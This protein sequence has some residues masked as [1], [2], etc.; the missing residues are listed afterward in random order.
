MS[1]IKPLSKTFLQKGRF[2]LASFL[3]ISILFSINPQ[4]ARA[5]ILGDIWKAISGGNSSNTTDL[6]SSAAAIA[7]PLLGSN[8]NQASALTGV[9]GSMD[10]S[11]PDMSSSQDS[12]LVAPRN[13]AGTLPSSGSDQ[14]SIYTVASGDTPGGIADKFGISL[15]TLLW[16][17]NLKNSR[18]IKAGDNLV[19][20]PVSGVQYEVKKGDTVESIA[21]KYRPKDMTADNFTSFV[22]DIINYNALAI[23][24]PLDEGN[25]IIIPDGELSTPVLAPPTS[26]IGNK[27]RFTSLPSYSGYYMRP[28]IGGRKTQGIH[29]Y[30]GVDLATSC[31]S[32]LYASAAGTV[33]IVR[34]SGWNSGYGKYVVITH[35]NSTQTLYGHMQQIIV[36]PGQQVGQGAV[37]GLVGTTGRSTGCHVHFEIRGAR[38]PF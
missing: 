34:D 28:V 9:G 4:P 10:D 33:I 27:N 7:L 6:N 5:G 38:N 19:I 20:L 3:I 8:N 30:N 23:N 1:V 14:I 36:E 22:N 17:N 16:A 29:G 13:P 25:V 35:G 26:N 32:P 2:I 37:I 15:N 12:A 21:K 18:S 24:A 31:G 11:A